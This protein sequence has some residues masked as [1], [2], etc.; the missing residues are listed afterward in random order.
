MRHM[1]YLLIAIL[2]TGYCVLHSYLI[3]IRFTDLMS[4]LLKKFYSFYRLF[5]VIISI[6]LLIPLINFT[7][8]SDQTAI[9][10][11]T[12]TLNLIRNILIYSSVFMFAWV[13]LFDYDPLSF[14]GI[15][16]ILNF[17]K[18]RKSNP[19]KDLKKN[20]MLGIIRHPMYFALIIFLWCHTFKISDIVVNTILTIYVIIGTRLEEKKLVLEFGETYTQY[21]K[22]VPMIFPFAI[23]K[24][25]N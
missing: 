16:Q 17:G 25:R 23:S 6:L 3:S 22:E 13:F 21:Q 9:I 19:S 2:W 18:I 24:V 20:G 8:E 14:L 10:T 5:Y 7:A 11:Y 15:R 1:K 12:Q 4:G